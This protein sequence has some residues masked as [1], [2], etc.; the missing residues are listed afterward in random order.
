M[1]RESLKRFGSLQSGKKGHEVQ[2]ENSLKLFCL[3]NIRPKTYERPKGLRES[4]KNERQH[5]SCLLY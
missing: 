2:I 1:I 5:S 4:N 3:K